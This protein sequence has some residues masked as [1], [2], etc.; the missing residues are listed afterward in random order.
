MVRDLEAKAEE[1]RQR[2]EQMQE[3]I[4]NTSATASS[5]DGAVTVRVAPNGALQ[6]IEFSE[7]VTQMS[8]TQLGQTVMQVA[9]KAQADAARQIASIVEPEF[10]DTEA[11][12]FLTGFLPTE[13]DDSE[14]SP[15]PGPGSRT[16]HADDEDD[17]GNDTFLR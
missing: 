1:L 3:Q 16:S 14:N 5:Q 7:R 13:E 8:H 17:Y 9:H 10:G 12:S 4:Q 2:S 15:N 11:M 6:H